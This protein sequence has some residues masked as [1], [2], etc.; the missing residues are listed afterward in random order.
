MELRRRLQ[1][2]ASQQIVEELEYR[3]HLHQ[4]QNIQNQ[5]QY[6]E[7][8]NLMAQNLQQQQ[9]SGPDMLSLQDEYLFQRHQQLL[10]QEQMHQRLMAQGIV[11]GENPVAA[12]SHLNQGHDFEAA[13][14]AAYFEQE[15][16]RAA[17]LSNDEALIQQT[18]TS[19][20][21]N[22]SSS[23]P[24]A[25]ASPFDPRVS[26]ASVNPSNEKSNATQRDQVVE[27]VTKKQHKEETKVS[28]K[29]VPAYS[30]EERENLLALAKSLASQKKSTNVTASVSIQQPGNEIAA[31]ALPE[32]L[33][34]PNTKP[35]L[36]KL[37]VRKRKNSDPG[38]EKKKEKK[39]IQ[40]ITKAGKLDGRTKKAREL[41]KQA[42]S[43]QRMLTDQE[44]MA[45]NFLSGKVTDG[46]DAIEKV[47][48]GKKKSYYKKKKKESESDEDFAAKIVLTFKATE[49]I[50]EHEVKMVNIWSKRGSRSQY[51]PLPALSELDYPELTPNLKFNLPMLPVEPELDETGDSG[52]S[53]MKV[54]SLIMAI[55][56]SGIVTTE[57]SDSILEKLSTKNDHEV[58]NSCEERAVKKAKTTHIPEWWPTEH[59]IRHE[60]ELLGI[61]DAGIAADTGNEVPLADK[62]LSDAKDRLANSVE[63]GVL[64]LLP[65]CKLG[66]HNGGSNNQFCFQVADLFPDNPMVCCSKCSTW[67]HIKCGGHYKRWS[68]RTDSVNSSF[69]PVCDR[70]FSEEEV[71]KHADEDVAKRIENQRADHLRRCNATNAVIQQYAFSRHFQSKWPLGSVV[72]GYFASHSKGVQGRHEKAEKQWDEICARLDC[73]KQIPRDRVR[74]RSRVL[75]RIL[76]SVEDAGEHKVMTLILISYQVTNSMGP[77]EYDFLFCNR[78]QHGPSQYDSLFAE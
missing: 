72:P 41:K 12:R 40:E 28:S 38:S 55:S 53:K 26:S 69:E 47:D 32:T 63:P 19:S 75:E 65:H 76:H 46:S 25:E 48:K 15:A 62:S 52:T 9:P 68:G 14:A 22:E 74:T 43:K 71:L 37:K 51:N 45:I 73:K 54:E 7:F 61:D 36:P 67:R 18:R 8:N 34:E 4:L 64:E 16:L 21:P 78:D 70:C 58:S 17:V 44:K 30:S 31:Q 77:Y 27:T 42:L 20:Q 49:N 59:E 33:P 24:A 60:R 10:M 66:N 1:N 50:P 6:N 3:N 11:R 57:E 23:P 13:A 5:P 29:S 35:I 56:S 2:L 39:A